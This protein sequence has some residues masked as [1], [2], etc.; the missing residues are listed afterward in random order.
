MTTVSAAFLTTLT[1]EA[2]R[3]ACF[4]FTD[5]RRDQWSYL[6]GA[7]PG[8]PLSDLGT[9]ARK[10][11]HQ[12]LAAALSRAAFAQAVTIMALEEVLDIDE[13]GRRGR[14]SDGYHV[15][16]F[17]TPGDD[18]WAWRFEGHHLSVNVTVAAGQPVAAPLFMGA[19]PAW[20]RR[21]GHLVIAPLH[22]E[23]EL[24][25]ALVAALPARLR[26]QAS[27]PGPAPG[28]I[29]TAAAPAVS[30]PLEPAGVPESRMP[31]HCRELLGQLTS[32]YLRR[33]APDL[34]SAER[35]RIVRADPAF[36]WAGVQRG[37]EAYYYRVQA[38]GLLIEYQDSQRDSGHVHT[39]I[40][41]PGSDFGTAR[42]A[43]WPGQ[44][45]RR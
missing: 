44:A 36:A 4:G 31:G 17:G 24:A 43:V 45:A 25:R 29:V 14:H 3:L 11:A 9:Q 1:T 12:L 27:I 20:V 18:S 39:V 35:D 23:E 41:R 15:A 7:R 30:G 42:A 38:P 8:V 32:T 10:A 28:D 16:V 19:N 21:D 22:R 37:G 40:R 5:A 34:A 33:L 13:Q 6:P 26:D 2:R